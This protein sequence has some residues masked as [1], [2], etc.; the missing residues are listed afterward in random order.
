MKWVVALLT[1]SLEGD[2]SVFNSQLN[3]VKATN[4]KSRFPAS[5]RESGAGVSPMLAQKLNGLG[6]FKLKARVA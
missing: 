1:K 2:I 6:S 4:K 5:Y 3:T